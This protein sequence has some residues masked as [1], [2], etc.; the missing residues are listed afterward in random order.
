MPRTRREMVQRR[1][2]QAD[3]TVARA[4]KYLAAVVV[5]LDEDHP[6][7][8]DE[9]KLVIKLLE[10]ARCG[11]KWTTRECLAGTTSGLWEPGQLAEILNAAEPI[12]APPRY[13]RWASGHD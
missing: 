3:A 5:T 12:P 7:Y 4:Q 1:I 8:A 13:R 11:I 6:D 10:R 9:F 2:R